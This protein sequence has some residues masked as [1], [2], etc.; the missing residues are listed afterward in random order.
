ML[1]PATEQAQI[2]LHHSCQG[3]WRSFLIH[4]EKGISP[5]T[6]S[7]QNF[8][9]TLRQSILQTILSLCFTSVYCLAAAG[10][11]NSASGFT[12]R[13]SILFI[14]EFIKQGY[15]ESHH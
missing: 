12:L 1:Q 2:R 14:S 5:E 6:W 9:L 4:Q 11:T 15:Q 7:V 8:L 3:Q 10:T 13:I